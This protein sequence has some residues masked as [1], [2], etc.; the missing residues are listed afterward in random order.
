MSFEDSSTKFFNYKNNCIDHLFLLSNFCRSVST[1]MAGSH[2]S[3]HS[4]RE[5]LRDI[6]ADL[7]VYLPVFEELGYNLQF[8]METVARLLNIYVNLW[9]SDARLRA[10]DPIQCPF[11]FCQVS[12][13]TQDSKDLE[14]DLQR[15]V[16]KI[17]LRVILQR[18][19]KLK[20]L[21]FSEP[22][23]GQ[24]PPRQTQASSTSVESSVLHLIP[25]AKGVMTFQH[26]GPWIHQHSVI[27]VCCFSRCCPY[28]P[29]VSDCCLWQRWKLFF[30]KFV[31]VIRI[32]LLSSKIKSLQSVR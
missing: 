14:Q 5:W 27:F 22:V 18:H 28:P 16:K 17:H 31:N 26:L 4:I 12:W 25:C 20:M 10:L 3:N 7:E 32:S 24:T 2:S 6:H 1:C 13:P 9:P 19:A 29:V 15:I 8:L 30:P 23:A 11:F 21:T